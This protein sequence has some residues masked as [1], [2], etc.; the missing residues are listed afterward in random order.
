MQDINYCVVQNGQLTTVTVQ[1]NPAG[2]SVYNGQPV[3]TA[4]PATVGYAGSETWFI[5]SEPIQ[6]NGR[7]YAKYGLPRTLGTT[8][9]TNVGTVNNV[10]VFA[11]PSANPQRPEVIYIPT[12]P[13][14]EFQ[15]YQIEVKGSFTPP[16]DVDHP[17]AS[18]V[19]ARSAFP[20]A[21]R[22]ERYR[23]REPFAVSAPR[24]LNRYF[25]SYESDEDD[26]IWYYTT[27][28]HRLPAS[29]R[30][31]VCSA[32][33][34]VSHPHRMADGAVAFQVRTHAIEK[35]R[36]DVARPAESQA[37]VDAAARFAAEVTNRLRDGR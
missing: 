33:L 9:V 1:Y 37:C 21:A 2:D 19:P 11:E 18:E 25:A 28:Y 24:V 13:G 3:S 36:R 5:N 6:F 23:G 31:R 20:R 7:R 22:V 8:D 12:R 14:C 27:T 34:L 30:V 32:S 16:P 4:F 35:P 10:S 15:P 29:T 26:S 17:P